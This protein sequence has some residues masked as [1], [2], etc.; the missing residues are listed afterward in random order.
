M[1]Y[2]PIPNALASKSLT[3]QMQR[4]QNRALHNVVRDTDDLYKTAEELIIY[5][6]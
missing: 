3:M 1:E 2:P 5:F 6:R 4:V